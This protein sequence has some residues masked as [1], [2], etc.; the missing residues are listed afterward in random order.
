M[1]KDSVVLHSQRFDYE[2][3]SKGNIADSMLCSKYAKEQIL[4]EKGK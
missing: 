1:L 3:Y 4:H 2:Q